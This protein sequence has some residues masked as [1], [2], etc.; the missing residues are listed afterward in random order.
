MDSCIIFCAAEFH[1]LAEPIGPA[2]FLI[3][4][5]GGL[6]HIQK[7][8]IPCAA[9]L[10]DFDSL[11]YVPEG[12]AVFPVEK[13]DTDAMLAVRLGLEKGY[14]RFVIYG[15]MDGP[16]VDHTV[17]NLQTLQYLADRGAEGYLVGRRYTAT[18]IR[19]QTLV[20]PREA[21]GILSLFCLNGKA[22]GVTLK[23]LKYT[24]TDGTLSSGF[25]LGVSNAFLGE[26]ASVTVKEGSVL[27]IYDRSAGIRL[28]RRQGMAY[29][30]L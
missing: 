4:A 9:V 22:T 15:G 10:G 16:R 2:D 6:Q 8:R 28:Q 25:P 23:N 12:A 7:L 26:E 14:R 17:A 29:V 11:G 5:D 13:D 1:G 3:A 30:N 24:L 19:E 21:A 27:A 20:F 18:V